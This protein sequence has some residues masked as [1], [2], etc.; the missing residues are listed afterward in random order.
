MSIMVSA[1]WDRNDGV[2]MW[3][4]QQQLDWINERRTGGH[5]I[6]REYISESSAMEIYNTTMKKNLPIDTQTSNT[7]ILV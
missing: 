7:F 3:I 4:T 6:W 5:S 1:L 2:G